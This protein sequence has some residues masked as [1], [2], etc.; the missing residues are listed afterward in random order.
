MSNHKGIEIVGVGP[1]GRAE[2]LR[3]MSP[4]LVADVTLYPVE[5]GGRKSSALPGWG[6]PCCV[7]RQEPITGYDGWP[8]LGDMAIEPGEQRRIGFVF[9]SSEEAASILRKAGTFYLWEGRFIGEAK[10]VQSQNK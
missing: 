7:S 4:Q 8:L 9:L 2:Q 1:M 5:K 3:R 10:V 6:C